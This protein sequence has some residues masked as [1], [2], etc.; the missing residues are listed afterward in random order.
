MTNWGLWNW[1]WV[2]GSPRFLKEDS[3]IYYSECLWEI[4]RIVCSG[5]IFLHVGTESAR[6]KN[7][8]KQN[9]NK[10]TMSKAEKCIFCWYWNFPPPPMEIKREEERTSTILENW[11]MQD[12]LKQPTPAVFLEYLACRIGHN[13]VVCLF[14]NLCDKEG[15]KKS[16]ILPNPL[17]RKVPARGKFTR[18]VWDI[19]C[20]K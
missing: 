6:S 7:K 4:E 16:Q 20:E 2:K 13:L 18:V 19:W 1:Q 10:F 15:E 11:T 8:S 14:Q 5:E 12:T 17:C 9:K 3:C